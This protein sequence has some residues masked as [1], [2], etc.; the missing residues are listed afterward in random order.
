MVADIEAGPG[1]QGFEAVPLWV[2]DSPVFLCFSLCSSPPLLALLLNLLAL[3]PLWSEFIYPHWCCPECIWEIL[4]KPGWKT[5]AKAP[6]DQLYDLYAANGA[7]M[8][9]LNV[10]ELWNKYCPMKRNIFP[11]Y[12]PDLVSN[13]VFKKPDFSPGMESLIF[14]QR[15]SYNLKSVLEGTF[16]FF[17]FSANWRNFYTTQILFS[18]VLIT[19]GIYLGSQVK[20]CPEGS[21]MGPGDELQCLT[22]PKYNHND[23]WPLTWQRFCLVVRSDG[24]CPSKCLSF[25]AA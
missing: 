25:L 3:W 17:F 7:G 9:G 6:W 23:L 13:Q 8:E 10:P 16:W 1:T 15:T 4:P 18:C 19:Q 5:R 14:N 22:L 12:C 11:F 24:W 21:W 2:V 20:Q